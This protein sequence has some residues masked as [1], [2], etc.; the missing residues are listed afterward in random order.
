MYSYSAVH[1]IKSKKQ[2]ISK[3]LGI[4][5]NTFR[6]YLSI[7]KS[8]SLVSIDKNDILRIAGRYQIY[9]SLGLAPNYSE[10]KERISDKRYRLSFNE[11]ST[12]YIKLLALVHK[13]DNINYV[14]TNRIKNQLLKSFG[15]ITC[16]KIKRKIESNCKRKAIEIIER[17]KENFAEGFNKDSKYGFVD[18]NLSGNSIAGIFGKKSRITGN[19]FMHK[20]KKKKIISYDAR[21]ILVSTDKI[22]ISILREVVNKTAFIANDYV[23][24]RVPNRWTFI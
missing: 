8:K 6:K 18:D 16:P 15:T 23:Y 20:M 24:V 17:S 19:R 5:E 4:S 2:E 10:T 9:Y 14:N 7:L 22:S 3:K 12:D 11:L 1:N 13:R 21:S